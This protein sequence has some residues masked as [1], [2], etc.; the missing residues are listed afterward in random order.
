MQYSKHSTPLITTS[1]A[2]GVLISPLSIFCSL[3]AI[4]VIAI[5][6]ANKRPK[7]PI[8]NSHSNDFFKG[9]AYLE[10][11]TNARKLLVD[12]AVKYGQRP[13]AIQVPNGLK[14]I[15]PPSL[16][17]WVKNNK[18]VDHQQ[19]VR[20]DFF[21]TYP[22]FDVQFVLHHQNRMVIN[23][24]QGKLSKTD[25]TLPILNEYLQA[26]LSDIWGG[27][28]SWKSLD[29]DDGTTGV[30]SRAAASIFIG[31]ELASDPV[32]QKV[33]RAYVQDF[34]S[35][36]PEMQA[37]HPW[38]RSIRQWNLPHASACR[39]GLQRARE[40]V[41]AVA[42]KRRKEVEEAKIQGQEPPAY[43]D[44]LAW[45]LEN[46]ASETFE[47]GDVQL[48]LAMAALF[49]T[50][51]L[52]RQVLIEIARRPEYVEPLRK[53]VSD[54]MPDDDITAAS[55]V[56][57]QLLDSFMK[58]CQR[59]IPPLVILERLVI[60]D[61]QLPDG[62]PLKKGTHIAVD[63]REMLNPESFENP[64]DFDG[65]RFYRRREAGDNSSLF[66][67]SSP[68]HAHFGMGR[69]QCP[70]RFFAGSELKLCLAHIL[71]KYDMRLKDGYEPKAMEFGFMSVCDPFTQLEVKKSWFM[72]FWGGC[73]GLRATPL[74]LPNGIIRSTDQFGR[75]LK[76][77]LRD[78]PSDDL[79]DP[80]VENGL[81]FATVDLELPTAV[82]PG[83]SVV[84]KSM[85]ALGPGLV[86]QALG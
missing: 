78:V 43:Y 54:A 38:L 33:S 48:A 21:A 26:G 40:M 10:Y 9:R 12:G 4:A 16:S 50:S 49:T 63:G 31:P 52:F 81:V 7:F 15:L 75:T 13:F 19:L 60:H 80:S 51:E 45:T 86:L 73:R 70:G 14:V 76:A 34:F 5:I 55:L 59:Q 71:L 61:T 44:A 41:N 37:C 18:N 82:Q 36:V 69:H 53:E 57:M 20:D 22:G 2:M 74:Y 62:T 72:M 28:K 66:V 8:I 25:K 32:W 56:K 68:E 46:T 29:W 58:E 1:A 17:G 79:L 77:N 67:Q 47:P 85:K 23:M 42:Q 11:G 84:A 39:A 27:D 83:G 65:Y 3:L 6:S 30:I 35:A 64:G 24:I